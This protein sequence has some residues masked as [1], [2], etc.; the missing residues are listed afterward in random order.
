MKSRLYQVNN[1]M[2]VILA[3]DSTRTV[4]VFIYRDIQWSGV[5]VG[6]E[7]GFNVGDGYTSFRSP[8]SLSDET[9]NVDRLSNVG[10]PGVFVYRIDS[11]LVLSHCIH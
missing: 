8:L 2:Q 7:I 10:V 4:A 11:E 9:I 5:A 3:T 6:A 1:T